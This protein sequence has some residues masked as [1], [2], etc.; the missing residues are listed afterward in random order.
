MHHG[1]IKNVKGERTRERFYSGRS[2]EIHRA[3]RDL[4]IV[5]DHSQPGVPQ[6]IS[7]AERLVQDVLEGTRTALAR[8][9][10]RP[11]FVGIRWQALL[12]GRS[13]SS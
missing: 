6:N 10:V 11:S 12:Y 9:G 5:P 8:A 2:G 7:V 1:A 4:H 13:C 3:L